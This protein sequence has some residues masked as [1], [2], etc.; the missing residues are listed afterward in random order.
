[1][2]KESW[3]HCCSLK[4]S[5]AGRAWTMQQKCGASCVAN[6][7][8]RHPHPPSNYPNRSWSAR[9]TRQDRQDPPTTAAARKCTASRWKII[10]PP[11]CWTWNARPRWEPI[12]HPPPYRIQDRIL[13]HW[14]R[15]LWLNSNLNCLNACGQLNRKRRQSSN[16]RMLSIGKESPQ[17]HTVP[18]HFQCI[19]SAFPVHFQCI[20]SAVWEWPKNMEP[21]P[22]Y[23]YTHI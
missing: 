10:W 16:Y 14:G 12:L 22:L 1:M 6:R 18:V 9:R 11:S 13:R 8:H 4:G 23:I 20:S 17:S 19:S 21:T 3:I 15:S 5:C 7:R 2:D